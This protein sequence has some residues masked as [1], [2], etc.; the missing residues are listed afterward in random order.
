MSQELVFNKPKRETN[1]ST[2]ETYFLFEQ[3]NTSSEYNIIWDPLNE[4]T[5]PE[6][7]VTSI[8]ELYLQF[9]SSYF[10]KPP[11]VEHMK[12]HLTHIITSASDAAKKDSLLTM[13]LSSIK[14][15]SKKSEFNWSS[16]KVEKKES[17]D[18][19]PSDFLVNSRPS[20]PALEAETRNI[21]ITSDPVSN[22]IL[23]AIADIPLQD[24]GNSNGAFRLDD[25]GEERMF[26]LRLL[27]AKLSAKLAKYKVKKEEDKYY[28]R[29]GRHPPDDD[30]DDYE[31]EEEEDED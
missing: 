23:E 26:R 30:E 27:E 8:I 4:F 14:I 25:D 15:Y 28:S 12:K 17:D 9:A 1:T 31:T 13:Y 10:V 2:N 18:Q 7:I 6:D 16:C 19:I 11:T 3:N 22:A 21:T 29:F 20:S 24:G 5:V